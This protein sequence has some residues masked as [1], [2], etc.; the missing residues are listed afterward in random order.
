ME[1]WW[2]Q[3]S[4]FGQSNSFDWWSSK[5]PVFL[6]DIKLCLP[7]RKSRQNHMSYVPWSK[8]R[9]LSHIGGWSSMHFH[10]VLYSHSVWIGIWWMTTHHKAHVTWPK[11]T[12]HIYIYTYI[13]LY[14][15]L[16]LIYYILYYLILSYI[17]LYY[18][19]IL[20]YCIILYYI[21]LY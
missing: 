2:F 9:L 3:V 1:I 21:K 14:Y 16:Y 4:F 20:L 6:G 19:I 8:H 5:L 17:I 18:L 15:I 7:R 13:I 12:W 11:R 10:R